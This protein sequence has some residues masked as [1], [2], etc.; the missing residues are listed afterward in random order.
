MPI[1]FELNVQP[2]QSSADQDLDTVISYTTGTN[3]DLSPP[4]SPVSLS[5]CIFVLGTGRW[6]EEPEPDQPDVHIY[7]Y[8]LTGSHVTTP[9]PNGRDFP[10]TNTNM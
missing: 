4:L 5:S 6:E 2:R 8:D 7:T 9:L 3:P 10:T 1:G